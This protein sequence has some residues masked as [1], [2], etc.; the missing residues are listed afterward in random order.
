M[1]EDGCQGWRRKGQ[2]EDI[3]GRGIATKLFLLSEHRMAPNECPLR[4]RV[5]EEFQSH[6]LRHWVSF[7]SPGFL[8][9]SD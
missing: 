9:H 1:N 5:P 2:G 7:Y 8:V 6:L 3:V 4:K